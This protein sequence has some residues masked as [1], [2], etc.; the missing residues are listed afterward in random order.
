MFPKE[1]LREEEGR[2]S[3][4]KGRW[5]GRKGVGEEDEDIPSLVYYNIL[6]KWFIKVTRISLTQ[7]ITQANT[8]V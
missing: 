6:L 5:S 7:K 4:T 1:I 2:L 8:W 3:E